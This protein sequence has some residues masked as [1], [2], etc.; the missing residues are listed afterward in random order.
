VY[1]SFITCTSYPRHKIKRSDM[2]VSIQRICMSY[3]YGGQNSIIIRSCETIMILTLPSNAQ[4]STP[5]FRRQ[6]FFFFSKICFGN[7]PS[8]FLGV[9]INSECD[10]EVQFTVLTVKGPKKASFRRCRSYLRFTK[11]R[12]TERFTNANAFI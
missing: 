4:I 1:Y 11:L 12:H 3:S 9:G 2:Q 5:F 7:P 10:N 6:C 8:N